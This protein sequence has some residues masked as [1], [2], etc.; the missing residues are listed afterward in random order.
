MTTDQLG[1]QLDVHGAREYERNLVTLFMDDWARDLVA[2]ANVRPG[3]AVLD[4]GTGT[5]IVARHALGAVGPTGSVDAIDINPAMLEVARSLSAQA[6]PRP[7]FHHGA[8]EDLPF[9]DD[10]FDVVTAQHVLQFTDPA[11]ALTE[12]RRVARSGARLAVATC[13]SLAHQPGYRLLVE[14]LAEHLGADAA[15]IIS[16]PYALG[17]SAELIDLVLGNG[18]QDVRTAIAVTSTRFP[19]ATAFLQAESSSSPLG[20]VTESLE[21]TR[22]AALTDDLDRRLDPHTD[23]DG[24][25]FPFETIVVTATAA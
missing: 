10:L 21:P 25:V 4:V 5:G 2:R 1:W 11:P 15:D 23:S 8:A 6:L 7:T 14:G 22:L 20:D 3:Q 12:F 19:S 18:F 17:E 9:D 16:S 24:I 13:R